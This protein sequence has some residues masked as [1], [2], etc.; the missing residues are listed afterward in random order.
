PPLHQHGDGLLH[1]VADHAA[2][3]LAL[4]RCFAHALLLPPGFPVFSWSTVR[5]RAMSRRT[6]L[7]WLVLV[8][9]WV[10]FCM[11]SP[12]CAF[13]SELS[14]CCSSS[15]DFAFRSAAVIAWA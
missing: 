4:V 5:T 1:L 3:Q 12:N 7:N 9:C 6:L 10:A 11:R 14:S 15:A 8:S 13:R 2:G